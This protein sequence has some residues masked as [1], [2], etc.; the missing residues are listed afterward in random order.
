MTDNASAETTAAA[1]HASPDEQESSGEALAWRALAESTD[2][3]AAAGVWLRLHCERTNAIQRAL[4][5][6][7]VDGESPL[8]PAAVWPSAQSVTPDLRATC[9][10]ALAKATGVLRRAASGDDATVFMAWPCIVDGAVR[11]VVACEIDNHDQPVLTATLREL[12]LSSGWLEAVLR[13][14]ASHAESERIEQAAE[15]LDL[16]AGVLDEPRF[17]GAARALVTD[18][19]LRFDCDRVSLAMRRRGRARLVAMSHTANF[20]RRMNLVAALEAAAEE[21]IDQATAVAWPLKA[22]EEILVTRAHEGLSRAHGAQAVMT[23]PLAHGETFYGALVLEASDRGKLDHRMAALLEG[24]GALLAPVLEEK[25]END[26]WLPV[27]IGRSIEA[28]VKRLFGPRYIGRKLAA[29][30]IAGLAAFAALAEGTATVVADARLE[31]RVQRAVVAP[32]DGYVQAENARAGQVVEKGAVLAKLDDRDLRLERL[33]Y[34]A[35]REQRELELQQALAEGRRADVNVINARIRE[36]TAQIELLDEM[37]A[38]A[39]I[40]APFDGLVV[41]GDL[42]Q[43]VGS[44][45]ERGEQLFQLTPLEGYRVVIMVPEERIAEVGPGQTGEVRFAAFPD[46]TW[47]VTVESITPV[48]DVRDGANVFRVE[49][50]LDGAVDRLRP[51][52]EGVVRL[53]GEER[54]LVDIWSRPALDWLRLSLWRWL[55]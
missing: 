36:A 30:A 27:K 29:G 17:E 20:S 26:S 44:P 39:V 51:G 4:V 10:A 13:R 34:R 48:T 55:P 38:R 15:A 50:R 18:L 42:S 46:R 2:A 14:V 40:A 41:A 19:A 11:A 37:M 21:A 24:A 53:T 3:Q 7:R 12:Q 47:A 6:L 52:M 5:V 33:R 54:L 25:R 28:Q 31:G 8:R 9:E 32:F 23:V 35:G 16:M 43:K 45:V 1:S 22:D 49:G